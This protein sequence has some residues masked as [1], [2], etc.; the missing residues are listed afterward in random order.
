MI[1]HL[2]KKEENNLRVDKLVSTFFDN[3]S[4]SFISKNIKNFVLVDGA[5]VK[6]SY[7][8]KQGQRVEIDSE[9]IRKEYAE[10]I[11]RED[12]E[13][14]I[15]PQKSTLNIIYEDIDYIVLKKPPG[16]VVHPGI[17]NRENTLAN[18]VK[19]YLMEKGDYDIELSRAGIV[20][21]LDKPV[22]G[23]IV[24]AKNRKFQK[25][26]SEQFEKHKVLKI[27][28]A[29]YDVL[30][31][32]KIFNN[33]E[34]IDAVYDVI[35]K[36]KK[37]LKLNLE[38]WLEVSGT[39]KRDPSNRKRMLFQR[40]VI[41]E[42]LRYAQSYLLP[43]SEKRMCVLIKTGRMHQIRATLKGLGIVLKGDR[44]YGYKGEETERIGLSSVVLG[45]SDAKGEKK[46]FNI[47][48]SING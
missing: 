21:R 47:L 28:N 36:Y 11:Q 29:Q 40:N 5:K 39:M 31:E 25:C 19:N 30:G 7:R 41:D 13:S 48:N 43:L 24:F 6:P 33:F 3:I 9:S 17:G 26:L 2:V 23:L 34:R 42:K 44:L 18:Y 22:S 4:R 12:L 14:K 8:L 15:L 1:Q 46:V 45:F 38:K 20:H 35:E 37:G 10:H 16:L 32:Q 27:Y